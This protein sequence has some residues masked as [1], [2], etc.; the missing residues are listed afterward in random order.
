L[1]KGEVMVKWIQVDKPKKMQRHSESKLIP[2]W[3]DG[4]K[5]HED[6]G[7]K[8][9]EQD[10]WTQSRLTKIML[11]DRE[12]LEECGERFDYAPRARYY[13]RYKALGAAIM[14]GLEDWWKE[15]MTREQRSIVKKGT[16]P[17]IIPVVTGLSGTSTM[18]QIEA[19]E[20]ILNMESEEKRREKR[21]D[22]VESSEDVFTGERTGCQASKKTIK[23]CEK[24][25]RI[26]RDEALKIHRKWF[27]SNSENW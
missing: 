23:V 25:T 2:W 3:W 18:A 8:S 20:M 6:T 11:K 9:E 14:C 27:G 19:I 22:K 21:K 1:V 4:T 12:V 5:G 13:E 15:D 26:A 17:R 10:F 16:K 24:L 7:Q